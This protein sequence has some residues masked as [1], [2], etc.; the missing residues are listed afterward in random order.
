MGEE[1][2]RRSLQG[3]DKG[4]RPKLGARHVAIWERGCQAEVTAKQRPLGGNGRKLWLGQLGRASR[5]LW[6]FSHWKPLLGKVVLALPSGSCPETTHPR[7]VG[8]GD[9]GAPSRGR[10]REITFLHLSQVPLQLPHVALDSGTLA[11]HLSQLV[12]ETGHLDTEVILGRRTEVS[13]QP[14]RR[15]KG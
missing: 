10:V 7:W 14:G 9:G 5:D 1:P 12:A 2:G 15:G 6:T 11:L 3:G 8:E 13:R 4:Q